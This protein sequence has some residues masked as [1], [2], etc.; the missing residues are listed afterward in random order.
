LLR[1]AIGFQELKHRPISA[2]GDHR[3]LAKSLFRSARK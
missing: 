3:F 2:R 1:F